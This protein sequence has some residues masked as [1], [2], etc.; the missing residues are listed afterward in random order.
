MLASILLA[1][2]PEPVYTIRFCESLESGRCAQD[3]NTFYLG[4]RVFVHLSTNQEFDSPTITGS[5][6]KIAEDGKKAMGKK[7]FEIEAGTSQIIQ[8][9]PFHEF[10][11]GAL[12]NFEVSFVDQEGEIIVNRR[13]KIVQ[14]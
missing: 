10:G 6:Y 11:M 4:K 3:T 7:D 2:E 12:G 14:P 9:I 5:V 1:C 13:L 8:D